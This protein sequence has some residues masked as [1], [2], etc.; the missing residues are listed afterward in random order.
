MIPDCISQPWKAP[1]PAELPDWHT[2]QERYTRSNINRQRLA[3]NIAGDTWSLVPLPATGNMPVSVMHQFAGDLLCARESDRLRL[4]RTYSIGPNVTSLAVASTAGGPPQ[5]KFTPSRLPSPHGLMVFSDP[6]GHFTDT[7]SVSGR[8][9]EVHTPIVAASW[10][11]WDESEERHPARGVEV[12]W[13]IRDGGGPSRID[14]GLRGIWLTLYSPNS[15]D[16]TGVPDDAVIDISG[17]N[18][19]VGDMRRFDRDRNTHEKESWGPLSWHDE[20]LLPFG[21]VFSPEVAPNSNAQW[22]AVVYSTFQAMQQTHGKNKD[23]LTETRTAGLPPAVRKKAKKE[24]KLTGEGKVQVV[25][26]AASLRPSKDATARDAADSDGLRQVRFS[27]RWPVLP[28][29]RMTCTN[30]Y[31]HNKLR[32]DDHEHH[33]HREDLMPFQVRGPAGKPLRT[34]P[35]RT[36]TFD[37]PAAE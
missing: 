34:R 14:P 29:R 8:P 12:D 19:T 15:H 11:L 36:F 22:A 6:I 1:L 35:G 26:L 37:V 10:S 9:I 20:I 28:W 27:H 23:P 21:G 3:A 18:A 5:E 31:L 25:D 32:D 24:G 17:G 2:R 13:V 7:M 30:P 4:A 33:E 16:L